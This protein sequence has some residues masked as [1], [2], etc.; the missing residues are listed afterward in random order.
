MPCHNYDYGII[1]STG[2]CSN[3]WTQWVISS[4]VTSTTVVW[5][6][7]IQETSATNIQ[8]ALHDVRAAGPNQEAYL[9]AEGERAK[10]RERA[11]KLLQEN[12][13]PRQL[14]QLTSKGY[15]DLD[16]ISSNGE[17]RKYRINRG[18]HGN[19]KRIDDSGKVLESL[20]VQPDNVPVEDAMLAQKLWLESNEEM[21]RRVANI[22]RYG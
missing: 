11:A 13:D 21:L 5:H 16:V 3:V 9:R 17:R 10:A 15:F 18:I 6:Q 14:E 22:T 7:W 19:V 20:C 12:L 8:A 2:S 1:N 4:C